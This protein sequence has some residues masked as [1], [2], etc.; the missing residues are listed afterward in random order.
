MELYKTEEKKKSNLFKIFNKSF[1]KPQKSGSFIDHLKYAVTENKFVKYLTGAGIAAAA[2][3]SLITAIMP[4]G[5]LFGIPTLLGIVALVGYIA[6]GYALNNALKGN[7]HMSYKTKPQINRHLMLSV[8]LIVGAVIA[9][10]MFSYLPF[11]YLLKHFA[12]IVLVA[13]IGGLFEAGMIKYNNSN[14]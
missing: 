3:V 9:S 4:L 11:A 14:H 1:T 12:S 2:G 7:E 6:G 13:G 5:F 8:G 10:G